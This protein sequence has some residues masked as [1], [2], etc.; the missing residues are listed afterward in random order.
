MEKRKVICI[1]GSTS[2]GKTALSIAVAKRVHGEVVSADSRQVYRGLN[3]GTGKITTEEMEGIPHHLLDVASPED[4]YTASDYIRDARGAISDIH[5]RGNLPL[6]VGGSGFYID[7]LMGRMSVAETAP[8]IQRRSEL[9]S[10][11]L[12]TLQEL[13]KKLDPARFET[14]DWQNPRRLIRAIEVAEMIGKNPPPKTDN[15]YNALWIGLSLARDE[16]KER[17]KSRLRAR[18]ND[19]M[20][21]EA[22]TLHR[23][24]LSYERMDALGLE[25]RALATLLKGER[26]RDEFEDRLA[27][28]IYLYAKRQETWF[29]RNTDITWYH[30]SDEREII[31]ECIAFATS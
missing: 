22:Q 31:Q 5:A 26:T 1:V 6:V 2:S 13:L 12:E 24:G 4:V 20:I 9:A 10:Y 27:S 25:Y 18:I 17:I 11:S 23:A 29:K 8:D 15:P 14:I 19:G 3:L 30:P 7:V 21:E 28:D 16:L